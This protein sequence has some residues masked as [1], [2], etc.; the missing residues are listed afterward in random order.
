M[1]FWRNK[2]NAIR[3]TG[4]KK[5]HDKNVLSTKLVGIDYH[6]PTVPQQRLSCSATDVQ[7]FLRDQYRVPLFSSPRYGKARISHQPFYHS[8]IY[9]A[10]QERYLAHIKFQPSVN[11]ANRFNVTIHKSGSKEYFHTE[12]ISNQ[13]IVLSAALSIYMRGMAADKIFFNLETRTFL[14]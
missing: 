14:N 13:K 12:I 11:T 8:F 6:R 4:S 9:G 5:K 2:K 1:H 3:A 10:S 7:R